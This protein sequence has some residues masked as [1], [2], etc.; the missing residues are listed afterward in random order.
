M[1]SGSTKSNAAYAGGN[2]KKTQTGLCAAMRR[3]K[4]G[5]NSVLTLLHNTDINEPRRFIPE[6]A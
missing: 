1:L 6:N 5:R 3:K 4:N 2:G